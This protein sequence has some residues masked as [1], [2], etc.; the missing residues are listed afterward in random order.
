[1]SGQVFETVCIVCPCCGKEDFETYRDLEFTKKKIE[2]IRPKFHVFGHIHNSYGNKKIGKTTYINCSVCNEDYEVTSK[3]SAT[4]I[5]NKFTRAMEKRQMNR[6][7]LNKFV[8][9]I[10]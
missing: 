8:K 9:L 5:A 4:A 3:Q 2:E 1:M 6:P 10:A 7:L